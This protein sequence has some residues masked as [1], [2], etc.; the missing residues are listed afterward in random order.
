MTMDARKIIRKPIITEKGSRLQQF[1][2]KYVFEVDKRANK[3][4]IK[5]AIQDIFDVEVVSVRTINVRG[6]AKRMGRYQGKR[7]DWKKA[8][9]ALKE[10]DAIQFFES[11]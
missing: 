4:E 7:P 1:Q 11:L 9:V 10:G 3:I 8:I 6:K 5:K 2:N